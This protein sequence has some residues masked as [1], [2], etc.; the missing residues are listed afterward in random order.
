MR[1]LNIAIVPSW[2]YVENKVNKGQFFYDQ[3]K[4]LKD[5]GHNVV[6]IDATFSKT[7]KFPILNLFFPRI[8]NDK[9]ILTFSYNTPA[10]GLSRFPRLISFIYKYKLFVLIKYLKFKKFRFDIFHAHSFFPAGYNLT[11]LVPSEKI[12]LTEHSS[13]FYTNKINSYNKKIFYKTFNHVNSTICVSL[14]LKSR[15]KKLFEF[16]QEIKVI[17]NTFSNDFK[18]S[19]KSNS[20]NFI[21][22]SVGNLVASKN[23]SIL[24]DAFCTHFGNKEGFLL[25]I[26][27]DGPEKNNLIKK[28]ERYNATRIVLFFGRLSR[29]EIA[30]LYSTVNVFIL[31][32]EY[33]TFGVSYIEA[34]ATG[35][36]VIGSFNGG[37]EEIIDSSNGLLCNHND[38]NDVIK[39]MVDIH[40]KYSM[41]NFRK[42][43]DDCNIKYSQLTIAKKIEK[44]YFRIIKGN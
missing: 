32:S 13:L 23:H 9:G 10:L 41:Y 28:V 27:G 38:L 26:V 3:A 42:I 43:S 16:N 35:T 2:Y 33:E 22:L 20:S 44:E 18:F 5:I 11:K 37:A 36:P 24:I 17:P 4:A 14:A 25:Y 19:K 40:F 1:K 6:V 30:R 12:L 29:Q 8:Y 7:K 21:Y 34:L 39:Q 31:L 15:I